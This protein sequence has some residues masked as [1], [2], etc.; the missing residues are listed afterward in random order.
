MYASRI[1]HF[2]V[3]KGMMA[4]L[5]FPLCFL[6][7]FTVSATAGIS[8]YPSASNP[9]FTWLSTPS[10]LLHYDKRSDEWTFASTHPLLQDSTVHE[11][12]VDEDFIWIA[13]DKGIASALIGVANRA[14]HKLQLDVSIFRNR[15]LRFG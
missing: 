7:T 6:I 12:G 14:F 4:L 3:K 15:C 13:T 10:G 1:Y 5:L 9:D 8:E 2:F 11:I